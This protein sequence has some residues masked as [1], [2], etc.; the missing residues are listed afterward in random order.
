[1]MIMGK[2]LI[3]LAGTLFLMITV[4]IW[5]VSLERIQLNNE[6]ISAVENSVADRKLAEAEARLYELYTI[7]RDN[8]LFIADLVETDTNKGISEGNTSSILQSYLNSHPTYFQARLIDTEG[9]E[10]IRLEK[11]GD[12]IV[13]IDNANPNNKK[14]RHYFQEAINLASDEVYISYLDLNE[15]K[16]RVEIPF[17]PTIRFFTPVFK[18]NKL[19]GIIGV[20]LNAQSWLNSFRSQDIFLLNSKDQVFLGD[21]QALYRISSVD[22]DKKDSFGNA[23]YYSKKVSLE[24]NHV[25]QLYTK[26]DVGLI[27]AKKSTYSNRI[28][29]TAAA[30]SAGS[31][32]FLIIVYTFYKKNTEIAELN[33]T[34]EASLQERNTLLKEIH[35]RVKNNLQVI[36]SLLSLQ[37]SF[38]EEAD[39]KGLLRYSQYRIKSMAMIH[40]M[41]YQSDNLSRINYGDYLHNLIAT[42]IQSMKGSNSGVHL[43]LEADAIFLNV[44]TSIPLGLMINEIITNSLKYGFRNRRDGLLTI[45]LR[46][47]SYPGF[48]L[49]IGD[50]GEG[51]P[52]EITFRNTK[53][54]GLKL[55]H[56]LVLQLKG[57]IEKDSSKPGTHYIV[58]FQEI[59][60]KS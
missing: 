22:L 33:R 6:N 2:I 47:L 59:E 31:L 56:K 60:Q 45:S 41:L 17:R 4:T 46:K 14:N 42:L 8:V 30:L 21:E 15:E 25:W 50:N 7:S 49:K 18:G 32:L 19:E 34:R 40:E 44:D 51:F 38:V 3:F 20:N 37:S 35:H 5:I 12:R 10:K 11:L 54:L 26:R 23:Y 39:T 55:I 13:Q 16:G 1:M 57:N 28:Y 58:T 29:R 48:L 43:E 52:E 9:R 53:S 36:T 27:Q 24:G